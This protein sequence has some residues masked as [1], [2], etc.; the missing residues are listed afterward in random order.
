LSA[1]VRYIRETKDS[2][3]TQSY[4]MWA[5]Q[6]LF[7]EN[8]PVTADQKFTEWTPEITIAY[9]PTDNL[10]LFGGYRSAYKSGGFSESALVVAA[11]VPSDITFDPETVDGFEVGLKGTFHDDQLRFNINLYS[12]TYED[13]QVD[14]FD[15]ITFQFITTNAG[16]SEVEGVELE[17]DFAPNTVPGLILSGSLNYNDAHYKDYIAPCYSGQSI[18]AGCD[19]TFGSGSGQD[20]SGQPLAMAPEWTGLIGAVY[21]SNIGD[22]LMWELAA[23]LRYSDDFG[24]D[25][26]GLPLAEQDSYFNLDAALK[27]GAQNGSWELALIGRNLTDT[28]HISGAL[29]LPN[30]GSGTGAVN[31]IAADPVGLVDLPRTVQLQ[32]THRF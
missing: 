8:Q 7:P 2:F 4:V 23:S 20:L 29:A 22:G 25:S 24:A 28:F 27:I 5:L 17:V 32:Y 14:F 1:G 19:T 13:L 15:S 6:E 21:S 10:T 3:L 30:S 16:E 31:G 26:F 18:S 12:Y 9:Y 11:T